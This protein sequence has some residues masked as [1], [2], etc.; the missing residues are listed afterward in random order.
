MHYT[1]F[2]ATNAAIQ[3][4]SLSLVDSSLDR[5]KH[6]GQLALARFAL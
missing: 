3:Y 6:W 1:S 5:T 2:I 4:L